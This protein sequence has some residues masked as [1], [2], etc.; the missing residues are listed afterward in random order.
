MSDIMNEKDYPLLFKECL[1]SV[2]LSKYKSGSH[3]K[4]DWKCSFCGNM[5]TTEIRVR[6][7][8]GCGC[9]HCNNGDPI[10]L[11]KPARR[12]P[13]KVKREYSLGYLYPELA[14]MWD[15]DKNEYSAF[16]Y[17][18]RS[19]EEVHW[20]CQR[21]GHE[22]V[23]AI[24]EVAATV[25]KCPKCALGFSSSFGEQLIY[26]ACVEAYGKE[27]VRQRDT[28]LGFEIDVFIPS[29]N[30]GIE[31]GAWHWHKDRQDEDIAKIASMKEQGIDILCVYDGFETY[32][33]AFNEPIAHAHKIFSKAS[34]EDYEELR[35]YLAA[36]LSIG[37]IDWELVADKAK[38]A[39]HEKKIPYEK[40]LEGKYPNVVD[41]WDYEKNYPITPDAVAAYSVQ[42]Y[43]FRCG[44]GH[45]YLAMSKHKANRHDGCPICRHVMIQPGV[46]SFAAENPQLMPYWDWD[47]NDEDPDSIAPVSSMTKKEW[48]WRCPECQYEWETKQSFSIMKKQDDICPACEWR[49]FLLNIIDKV[50]FSIRKF[51]YYVSPSLFEQGDIKDKMY[52]MKLEKFIRQTIIDNQYSIRGNNKFLIV[53]TPNI[54]ILVSKHGDAAQ[55]IVHQCYIL[56][57]PLGEKTLLDR[58]GKAAFTNVTPTDVSFGARH[59]ELVPYWDWEKNEND[60]YDIPDN[61]QAQKTWYWKCPDC[62]H[63][64]NTTRPVKR[65]GSLDFICRDCYI[66][67]QL[68]SLL[69]DSRIHFYDTYAL[70]DKRN[71]RPNETL[72]GMLVNIA[73]GAGNVDM[74]STELILNIVVDSKSSTCP[75]QDISIHI[76][77][78]TGVITHVSGIDCPER[79]REDPRRSAKCRLMENLSP[80][81]G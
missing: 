3:K 20:V 41:E 60:P 37:R 16:D 65:G 79:P 39:M 35:D 29:E 27:E 19:A 34:R 6:A 12:A 62:G 1:S 21:C 75:E 59:P 7:Q 15:N 66:R 50:R 46:N 80:E 24:S 40:T 69:A 2:E 72:F 4:M 64:W 76:K 43:F 32:Q 63:E 57:E 33:D 5:W 77:K 8:K 17:K 26:F 70:N 71:I 56:D 55:G 11:D 42:K 68:S 36:H 10:S 58:K 74:D 73:N 48:H 23:S 81:R 54:Y 52:R 9:P 25:H 67:E 31:Y 38:A 30:L 51:D 61:T 47:K 18:P 53:E 45:S 22:F 44:K 49:N 78:N 28:S 14:E 13:Q